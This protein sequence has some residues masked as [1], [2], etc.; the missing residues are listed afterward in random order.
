VS[1]DEVLAGRVEPS[2]ATSWPATL[3]SRLGIGV[4]TWIVWVVGTG[5]VAGAQPTTDRRLAG[6]GTAV[7]GVAAVLVVRALTADAVRRYLRSLLAG[8]LVVAVTADFAIRLGLHDLNTTNAAKSFFVSG[9]TKRITL[10]FMF[11]LL[12]PLVVRSLLGDRRLLALWQDRAVVRRQLHTMDWIVLAY[13]VVAVPALLLGLAH[14]WSLTYVA[15]DL[16]LVVFFVFMYF[17]GRAA[18]AGVAGVFAPE[19]I[20]VLLLVA[21]GTLLVLPWQNFA[22]LI[23]YVE[24]T[25]VGALAFLLLQP[26]RAHLLPVGVAAAFLV[27]DAISIGE[28][29]SSSTTTLGLLSALG[30]LAYLALRLRR[31]VPQWLLVGIAVVAVVGF[32]GFTHD[33]AALRGQYHGSDPS[34]LGRT[35]EAHQVR[36]AVRGSPVSL[37]LGRGLGATIDETG[38][39]HYFKT[40]LVK[41][42]RNLSHVQEIHLLVFSFLLKM[43][44]LGVAWLAAFSLAVAALAVRG[45]ERAARLRNPA[46][47]LYAALPLL[48]IAAASGGA[49]NLQADPLNALTLGILVACLARPPVA[50]AA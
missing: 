16:G 33:G 2:P 5:L 23:L 35:Y 48:G 24:P 41:A 50:A 42:G 22:P 17:A 20:N 27:S 15:Q 18:D 11:V 4:G 46:F 49:S 28:G 29:N 43:G 26:R 1:A 34:N 21:V 30:I 9:E 7:A 40:T 32:V 3:R 31:L 37:V 45:F 12:G 36:A 14:R 8:I 47:V 13:C 38:A 25:A 39:P 6:A 44:L 10:P 19:L